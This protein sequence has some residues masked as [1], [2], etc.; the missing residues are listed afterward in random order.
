M[1]IINL[2]DIV[3]SD[4]TVDRTDITVDSTQ[5]TVDATF[6][7][8]GSLSLKIIPREYV[9][10]VTLTFYNELTETTNTETC[11]ATN[12]NG[13]MTIPFGYSDFVEGDSFEITVRDE[14]GAVLY[15]SKGYA[16]MEEDLENYKL[17]VKDNND[18][19]EM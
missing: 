16:T 7:P 8:G 3:D 9:D 19:I 2:N 10:V 14:F 1:K 17:N 15:R 11:F 18:I 13:Y 6:L 12:E 5:Y 4:L